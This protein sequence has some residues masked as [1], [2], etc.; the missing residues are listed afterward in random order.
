VSRLFDETKKAQW[1]SVPARV[2]ARVQ[3][4]QD[5]DLEQILENSEE[6]QVVEGVAPAPQVE[7]TR[8]A[9]LVKREAPIAIAQ[10]SDSPVTIEAYRTL[11]TRLMN[12]K[13]SAGFK[14]VMITSAVP[15]EGKTLTALNLALS[16]SQ[17]PETR[18]LLV[19]ADLRSRGLSRHFGNPE[20]AGVAEVLSGEVTAEDA[21]QATEHKNL[22]AVT[23]GTH[24][25]ELSLAEQFAGSQWR[26][27]LA[28]SG[29]NF[30]LVLVDS[31]PVLAVADSEMIGTACDAVIVVVRALQTNREVLQR[32][33]GAINKSKLVGLVYNGVPEGVMSRYRSGYGNYY[34][35][36]YAK[37]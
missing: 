6:Q 10:N 27:F 19:D 28:W 4:M 30:S 12:R 18:V 3:D 11:R 17:L 15:G 37:K 22:S 24:I 2:P 34:D 9:S 21:I 31:P 29:E 33:G 20:T 25:S 16:C 7:P 14:T 23:A 35:A 36:G 1:A 13:V 32:L 5:W 8:T 26:E